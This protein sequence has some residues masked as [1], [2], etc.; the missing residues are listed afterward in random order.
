MVVFDLRWSLT[1][2]DHGIAA[3]QAGH[4]PGAVFVD[5]DRDLSASAVTADTPCPL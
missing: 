2:P 5:L 1:D 4:I 3:Y